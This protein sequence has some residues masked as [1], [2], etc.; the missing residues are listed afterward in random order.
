[1]NPEA[2]K[3]E[4]EDSLWRGR[5]D[6]PALR[7]R[8]PEQEARGAEE[9][10]AEAWGR[11]PAAPR[12]PGNFAARV[13]Q[14]V[15]AA[16]QAEERAA[17]AGVWSG[18]EIWRQWLRPLGAVAAVCA[19]GLI[20]WSGWER[21]ARA[22]MAHTVAEVSAAVGASDVDVLRD[23]EAIRAFEAS[24]RAAGDVALLKAIAE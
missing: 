1:M 5:L 15:D 4:D 17:R 19:A 10:L 14:R 11:L 6:G 2:P 3:T 21:R 12:M 23:F 22:S 13:L 20:G 18:W 7:A 9:V 8:I 24:Q 16:G